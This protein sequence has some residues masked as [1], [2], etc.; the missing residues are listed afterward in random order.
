M[1]LHGRSLIG[2]GHD[3]RAVGDNRIF[4]VDFFKG[5]VGDD[6]FNISIKMAAVGDHFL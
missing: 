5:R 1:R 6:H 4:R 2:V 3:F